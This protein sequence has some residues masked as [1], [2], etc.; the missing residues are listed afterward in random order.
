MLAGTQLQACH[1]GLASCEVPLRLHMFLCLHCTRCTLSVSNRQ[2]MTE[3]GLRK[4]H[5]VGDSFCQEFTH[6][7]HA[8]HHR[9]LALCH[10]PFR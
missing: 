3:K 4:L 2:H 10:K 7:R 9:E 1:T 6:L 8:L 5:E